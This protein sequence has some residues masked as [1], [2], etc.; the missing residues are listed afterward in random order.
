M[1]E[2]SL[3][4]RKTLTVFDDVDDDIDKL[5][6]L[7]GTNNRFGKSRIIITIRDEHLLNRLKIDHLYEAQGLKPNYALKLF[8]H[9]AF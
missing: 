7:V 8:S 1:I 3:H 6:L 9:Y 2:N 4:F 5:E